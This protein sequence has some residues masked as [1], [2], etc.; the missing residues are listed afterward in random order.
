M[1]EGKEIPIS[2]GAEK[3]MKSHDPSRAQ[4]QMQALNDPEPATG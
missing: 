3:E 4:E 1:K 2:P